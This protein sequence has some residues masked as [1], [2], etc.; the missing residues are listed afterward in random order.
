VLI[1]SA[2]S[3]AITYTF[4]QENRGQRIQFIVVPMDVKWLPYA[5]L[6][7][8]FVMSGPQN[9]LVESMGIIAAHLYDFLTIYWPD[10]GGGSNYIQTPGFVNRLFFGNT[11]PPRPAGHFGNNLRAAGV[12]T[13]IPPNRRPAGQAAGSSTGW[14]ARGPGR[15]LGD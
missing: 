6:A 10:H 2:L 3:L 1:R 13:R 4:A 9:A 11:P 8:T 5:R 7:L 12:D 14:N 15:R